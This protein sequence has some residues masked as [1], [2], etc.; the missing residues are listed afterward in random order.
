MKASPRN[1]PGSAVLDRALLECAREP[2]HLAGAIQPNGHVFVLDPATGAIRGRS[3]GAPALTA[4]AHAAL[5]ARQAEGREGSAVIDGLATEDGATWVGT[6][7]RGGDAALLELET[8]DPAGAG[9]R[10]LDLLGEAID[11]LALST[12]VAGACAVAAA[13]L[14]TMTGFD[15]VMVYRFEP[16]WSGAVA[17]ESRAPRD[18]VDSF[19]GLR[20]PA[21]DIPPQARELYRLNRVRLIPDAAA[22]PVPIEGDPGVDLGRAILRAV[23]PVHLTYLANMGVRASMSVAI[24]RGERLWGLLA[25]HHQAGPLATGQRARQAAETL[26]RALAWR[27]AEIEATE[28]ANARDRFGD[29]AEAL[30][31]ELGDPERSIE[32]A[33]APLGV[34]LRAAAGA[35]GFL[36]VDGSLRFRA[37]ETGRLPA[38]LDA[39]LAAAATGDGFESDRVG[40]SALGAAGL[41]L[42]EAGWCGI[43]ARRIVRGAASAENG[44]GEASDLWAVWLRREFRHEVVWAGNP[45]KTLAEAPPG[46]Q[47]ALTPRRSFAAWRE[48]VRGR[49]AGLRP[50]ERAAVGVVADALRHALLRRAQATAR[51]NREL[52]ER[53]AAIRFFADAAVHDLREPLWQIQV[54]A[55]ALRED[56]EGAPEPG[57]LASV[58]ESSAARMRGMVDELAAFA[59]AGEF[60]GAVSPASLASLAGEAALDLDTR[61]RASGGTL[62]IRLDAL[63]R[64]VC[65]ASQ[66]RRV[67]QN[68]LS[69]AIKYR[70]SDLP[71]RIEIEGFVAADGRVRI[72]V[73]DNG[74]G[75]P[76]A[77]VERVFEPFRKLAHPQAIEVDGLGLGLAICRRVL[78]GHGGAIVA[79]PRA[80]HGTEFEI[81]LPVVAA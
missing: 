61:L 56:L 28:V 34:R 79:R 57:R 50:A 81:T 54:L 75:I 72:I 33:L 3:A 4:A 21:S 42:A 26:A 78:E 23:S 71:L 80:V 8:P 31:T 77:E 32:T 17:A 43:A 24:T 9:G 35:A 67:F 10:A 55:G 74:L 12:D 49:A 70:R 47:P 18:G 52:R 45:D 63:P 76:A 59:A 5:A 64:V 69:N 37:G 13:G 62:A 1:I 65:E 29:L 68:L 39:A 40:D 36:L 27:L 11:A 16:D 38:S 41:A 2:I 22:P 14:R 15:R 46:T 25:C 48:E 30:A 7:H 51:T 6:L 58:I 20:F 66:M 19:E 73:A 44:E 53:N 60:A